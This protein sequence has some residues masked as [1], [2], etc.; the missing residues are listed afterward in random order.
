[1]KFKR[2]ANSMLNAAAILIAGSMTSFAQCPMCKA[3]VANAENAA[4]VART[5]NAA[6][7]A[8]LVPTFVI[9]GGLVKLVLKYRHYQGQYCAREQADE[10]SSR[11][12]NSYVNL[13]AS[14]PER[15]PQ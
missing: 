2:L 5:I 14:D 12:I 10:G 1:M 13:T 6:I 8:L 4:E 7:L 3:S 9:I 15:D 11:P